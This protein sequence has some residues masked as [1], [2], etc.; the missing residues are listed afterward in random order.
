[1]SLGG[2]ANK[3]SAT[4]DAEDRPVR[5]SCLLTIHFNFE[6]NNLTSGS[7]KSSA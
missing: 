6:S 2:E 3:Y 4:P 7:G 1:M 5:A